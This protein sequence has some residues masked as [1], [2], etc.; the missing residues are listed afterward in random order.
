MTGIWLFSYIALWV[1]FLAVAVVLVSALRNMGVLYEMVA[2]LSVQPSNLRSAPTKLV[3]GEPVPDVALQTLLGE[4]VPVTHFRGEK[5]AFVIVNPGCSPCHTLLRHISKNSA[6]LDPQ[7]PSVQYK[8][9]VSL[10]DSQGTSS[11]MEQLDFPQD[12]PVLV[13]IQGE[14]SEKWG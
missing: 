11:M 12:I 14:V 2:R 6:N 10:G 1:L 5:M 9:I 4:V 8:V 7:D 3:P 13:D